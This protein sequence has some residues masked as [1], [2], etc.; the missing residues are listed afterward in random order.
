[1]DFTNVHDEEVISFIDKA[2]ILEYVSEEEIFELVLGYKPVE[3]EYLCSPLREDSNPGCW[4]ERNSNDRLVLVDY[5]DPYHHKEDCFGCVKRFFNLPN[6]YQTL[7]FIKNTL[8]DEKVV[9]RQRCIKKP[10]SH[11][12]KRLCQIYIKPRNFIQ[13]DKVYWYGK[14]GITRKQ[15]KEDKVIPVSKYVLKNTRKGDIFTTVYTNCYAYKEFE[16]NRTK[17]YFPFRQGKGRFIT[18]CNQN[19]IGNASNIKNTKQLVVTKSYKDCRVLRNLGVNTIWF[20]NEGMIPE[21]KVLTKLFSNYNFENIVVFFDNDETGIIAGQK[22]K[23]VLN[24]FSPSR[25]VILPVFL[26]SESIKDASDLY[27]EKGK[28]ELIKFLEENKIDYELQD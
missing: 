28:E 18:N 16:G 11:K 5:A 10:L 6:F 9:E 25:T 3:Y 8:I 20:Q 26:L 17:L 23:E 7:L 4:F 14:Y 12:E 13:S 2:K 15:L 21:D 27:C 24:K 1:M 19:D 22:V